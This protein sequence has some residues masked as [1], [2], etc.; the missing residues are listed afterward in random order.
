MPIKLERQTVLGSFLVAKNRGN[1]AQRP[2]P[3]LVG[4][5]ILDRMNKEQLIEKYPSLSVLRILQISRKRD[6]SEVVAVHTGQAEVLPPFTVSR[7]TCE[8][9]KEAL[10]IEILVQDS[11]GRSNQTQVLKDA[12]KSMGDLSICC[13]LI[14]QMKKYGCHL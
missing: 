2:S 4:C 5:N 7:V 3:V 12:S 13:W 10:D 9:R 8:L 11:I 14:D 6:K 1:G